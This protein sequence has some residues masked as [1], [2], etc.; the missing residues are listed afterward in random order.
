[1][2][3]SNRFIPPPY[4]F[5]G[6]QKIETTTIE[7]KSIY[8]L[9]LYFCPWSSTLFDSTSSGGI[10][11]GLPILRQTIGSLLPNGIPSGGQMKLL[12]ANVAASVHARIV[13]LDTENLAPATRWRT[14]TLKILFLW[15]I[16]SSPKNLR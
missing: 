4:I 13:R 16:K 6:V 5:E 14:I 3:P 12:L 15:G 1:M 2:T 11:D 7:P 10:L 9:F 8:L